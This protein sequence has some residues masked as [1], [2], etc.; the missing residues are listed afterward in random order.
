MNQE[1]YE[2]IK[3]EWGKISN[4]ER[5][6]LMYT[7]LKNTAQESSWMEFL[8]NHFDTNNKPHSSQTL[9][10]QPQKQILCSN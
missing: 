5:R 1:I 6:L 10:L 9:K 8:R 2:S 4:K 7:Y 3:F